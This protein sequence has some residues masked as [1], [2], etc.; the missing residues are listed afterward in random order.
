MCRGGATSVRGG[1]TSVRGGAISACV[2]VGLQV[3]V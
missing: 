1:A 2:G 3:H